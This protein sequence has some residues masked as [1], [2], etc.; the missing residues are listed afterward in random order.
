LP[1]RG[2]IAR[3]LKANLDEGNHGREQR[4]G[5]GSAQLLSRNA[6]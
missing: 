1:A 6:A 2:G 3:A 5:E 4:A